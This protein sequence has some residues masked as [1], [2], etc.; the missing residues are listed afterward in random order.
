M[1]VHEGSVADPAATAAACEESRPEVIFHLAAQIDVRRS[2][3]DPPFDA[4]VNV[5][6]T[7]RLLEAAVLSGARRFVLASTGGA[8]YGETDVIPTPETTS[9]RPLSPYAASKASAEVYVDLYARLHGLSPSACDGERLRAAPGPARRGGCDRASSAARP[10]TG[11][12][13]P[14]SLTAARRRDFVYVGDVVEAFLAAGDSDAAGCCN[15]ATGRETTV[16]NSPRRSDCRRSPRRRAGRGP[17][18]LPR[19]PAAADC[20]AGR[21]APG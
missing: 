7:V 3:E 10:S 9:P 13:R 15:V 4:T 20:S 2:V 11:A 19:S 16:S 8:I 14:C 6:G 1:R 5:L 17:P 21:R 18:V 12:L